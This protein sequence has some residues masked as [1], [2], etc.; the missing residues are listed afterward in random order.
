MIIP[1][2]A[3]FI[4]GRHFSSYALEAMALRRAGRVDE[5][6]KLL[7]ALVEAMEADAR[8]NNWSVAPWYYKQLAILYN[9]RQDTDSELGILERYEGLNHQGGGPRPDLIERLTEVR[10]RRQ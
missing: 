6:E 1:D 5:A 3:G 8:A 2:K 7:L 4:N 10:R 9:K